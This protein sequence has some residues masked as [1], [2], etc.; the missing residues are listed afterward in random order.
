LACGTGLITGAL[1]ERLDDRARIDSVDLDPAALAY[2]S[3]AVSDDRVT[4]HEAD[5]SQLPF[6]SFTADIVVCN[7]GLQF[8][9][10]RPLVLAEVSR[11]LR[12]GGRLAL[13]VW[14][15]L[16][17]N[18]WPAAMAAAIG[19]ALGEEARWATESV[20]GLG[21]P[22]EVRRLLVEGGFVDVE[23]TDVELTATHPDIRDAIDGQLAAVPSAASIDALGGD[24]RRK[25]ID[26]M[27]ANLD[28]YTSSDG[29]LS[30]PS[31][32]VLATAVTPS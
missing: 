28:D 29:G 1:L 12:P 2:A 23:I 21:D 32:S 20:C 7:Q 30:V 4:W 17:A 26:A 6:E 14:G 10:D 9:P 22:A 11:V 25:L 24:G 13:A 27:A 16:A 15:P 18:P 5:A 8:F 31:T 19:D 3:A